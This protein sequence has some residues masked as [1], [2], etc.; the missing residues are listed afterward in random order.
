[1]QIALTAC[2]LPGRVE[3]GFTVVA[4][5]S[6]WT[7]PYDEAYEGFQEGLSLEVAIR[8]IVLDD[9]PDKKLSRE[10]RAASPDLVLAIGVGALSLVKDLE[11]IPIV[12][13]MHLDGNSD[14][15]D[16]RNITGVDMYVEPNTQLD[17]LL[18]VL[19]RTRTIGILYDPART[20]RVA[21]EIQ[22]AAA[23]RNVTLI[24][25]QVF[26]TESVP[27]SAMAIKRKAD[28]FWMLPDLTV[29]TPETIEF[30]LLTTMESN[31]PI[32]AF[33]EKYLEQGAL[34]S[35]GVD[36]ADMG[37]QAGEMAQKILSGSDVSSIPTRNA[38]KAVVAINGK[39]AEKLNIAV[40]RQILNQ[41]GS[42]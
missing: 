34:L 7:E 37:R 4:V 11:N 35:I 28:V 22:S 10:I 36:P 2:F 38:R 6:A 21:L 12:Y 1:M 32:L 24:D 14:F 9:L 17:I 18:N 42:Q 41:I 13:A 27:S 30:L 29:L 8:R 31:I 25:G 33:S 40:D 39:I 15:S 20:G 23:R 26:R 16:K 5:Q 19:P 3:A